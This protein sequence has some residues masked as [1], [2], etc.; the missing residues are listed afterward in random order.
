MH[1][2]LLGTALGDAIG[3]PFEG[4]S[5]GRVARR[6][7][8]RALDH[9]LLLGRGM[10]SDDTEHAC[11]VGRALVESGGNVSVFQRSLA[12]Q[13]RRWFAAL[14]PGVGFATARA[15]IRLWLGFGPT[16]SGVDSAGNGP[17][18]RAALIG[19]YARDDAQLE[20]LV[21]ASTII[22]HR[23]PRALD[24]ALLVARWA[25]RGSG[26]PDAVLGAV[27]GIRD[28]EFE[29]R[30]RR[31]AAAAA[32]GC[33]LDEFRVLARLQ[34]GP[35]GFVV[36]TMTAVTFCWLRHRD[37]P[38]DAIAAAVALGGDTDTVA[39]IVGAL[40][41]AEL[42]ARDLAARVPVTWSTR[43]RDWPVSVEHLRRLAAA[44]GSPDEGAPRISW[45]ASFSRNLAMLAIV[46]GHGFARLWP[47][48]R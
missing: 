21:E 11:M 16:R 17:C 47:G 38:A 20:R 10:I 45:L 6:L 1:G 30:V 33:S 23:D 28:G 43:L 26:D 4:L 42:G 2:V 36:E 25:R 35:T 29:K 34:A 31:A 44:L 19:V 32:S 41:G 40:L 24:G 7:R 5:P 22:T 15:C 13:L 12:C 3:L 48:P 27:A 8:G 37:R 46:L 9:S 18:M 14:P 39:A